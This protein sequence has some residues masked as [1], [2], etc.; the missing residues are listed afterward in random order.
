M[1]SG[2]ML[3]TTSIVCA[4]TVVISIAG[5]GVAYRK[6][7]GKTNAIGG[8]GSTAIAQLNSGMVYTA[9]EA[10]TNLYEEASNG[11]KVLMQMPKDTTVTFLALA[12]EG[13][14]KVNAN[15]NIGYVQSDKLVDNNLATPVP[16][17]SVVSPTAAPQTV[18]VQQQ[19]PQAPPPPQV[20][21]VTGSSDVTVKRTMYIV[22]VADSVYLRKYAEE[23]TDHYCTIPLGSAVGYIENVG[24]GFYK[25]KYSGTVGY[26]KEGYLSD[27]E[28]TRRSSS[29]SSV[30]YVSGVAHS[31]YLRQTPSD[32]SENICEI[33]VGSAVRFISNVGNGYYKISYNGMVGYA[34]AKYLR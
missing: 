16:T 23:N 6:Y 26:V 15:G 1:N 5:V 9:P 30:M 24:N 18:I 28:P 33:P 22:N 3:V 12:D 20:Q 34:T 19:Q 17:E 29:S 14:Y 7:N 21:H 13:F 32:P 4:A 27:Y 2:K 25:V 31:I 8:E 10:A 11:S